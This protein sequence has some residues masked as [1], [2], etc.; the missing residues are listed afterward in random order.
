MKIIKIGLIIILLL[1]A[2]SYCGENDI[3]LE[4][5]K[6]P[7]M[8]AAS[9]IG[10]QVSEV[11][12]PKS[13]K[14]LETAIFSNYLDSELNLSVPQN[15]ALEVNPYMIGGMINFD[16][17]SYI[18][19]D[20]PKNIWQNLSISI[21]STDNFRAVDSLQSDALGFGLRTL[22]LN[23]KPREEVINNFNRHFALDSIYDVIKLSVTGSILKELDNGRSES[24]TL[25]DFRADLLAELRDNSNL[26]PDNLVIVERILNGIDDNTS[27]IELE[28]EFE[29]VFRDDFTLQNLQN[30]REIINQIKKDRNRY[31]LR[32]E[33][34]LAGA[35]VFPTNEFGFSFVPRWGLWSNFS[36]K[37]PHL[38]NLTFIALARIIF[39]NDDY[40]DK[41]Q[42]IEEDHTLD[43]FRDIGMRLVY[44]KNK[45]SLE[46]EYIHRFNRDKIVRIIDGEEFERKINN[47]THKYV[48]NINYNIKDNI[49]VSYNIGKNFDDLDPSSGDLISGLS[50]NFGFGDIKAGDLASTN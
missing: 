4:D 19:N 21:S 49:T 41:Y 15:Y 50:V 5:L 45:F 36:Y 13:L 42:P 33:V 25:N 35:V 20:I 31:G 18:S 32:W 6:A 26:E 38:D 11:N 28:D 16:Y 44:E 27:L 10:I 8:P 39:N 37:S 2:Q 47:D 1:A 43:D 24:A 40:L 14:T 9:I 34:D 48:L 46:A 3:I 30:Y 12:Q 7:S 23:G 22:I 17:R 29:Q